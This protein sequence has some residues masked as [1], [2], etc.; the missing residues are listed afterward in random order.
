VPPQRLNPL[1]AQG[2][3]MVY[4]VYRADTVIVRRYGCENTEHWVA[5][6]DVAVI[7]SSLVH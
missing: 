3:A 7:Y 1:R 2:A 6:L 5:L 4:H